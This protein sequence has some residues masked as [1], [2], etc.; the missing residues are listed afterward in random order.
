MRPLL[1]TLVGDDKPTRIE[2][3]NAV[4]VEHGVLILVD[5]TGRDTAWYA[6]GI[7]RSAHHVP[8]Q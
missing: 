4:R 8:T 6:P 5:A 7:W 1:L 2:E 3:V